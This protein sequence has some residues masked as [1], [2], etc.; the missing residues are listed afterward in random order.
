MLKV[1]GIGGGTFMARRRG[2]AS[3]VLERSIASAHELSGGLSATRSYAASRHTAATVLA[4][5]IFL[6]DAG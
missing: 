5:F 4:A 3:G 6:P 1:A 2:R